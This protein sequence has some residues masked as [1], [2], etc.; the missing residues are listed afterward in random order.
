LTEWLGVICGIESQRNGGKW[1]ILWR[2]GRLGDRLAFKE[3]RRC[4]LDLRGVRDGH[5]KMCLI[6]RGDLGGSDDMKLVRVE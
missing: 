4:G 2:G 6:V 3:C 5:S 1:I